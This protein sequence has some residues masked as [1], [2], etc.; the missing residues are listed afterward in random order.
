MKKLAKITAWA[1]LVL[2]LL[3]LGAGCSSDEGSKSEGGT[4]KSGGEGVNDIVLVTR[5]GRAIRFAENDVPSMGRVSQGVKGISSFIV[6]KETTDREAAERVG[7]GHGLGGGR[8]AGDGHTDSAATRERVSHSGC[9]GV[10]GEPG[11]GGRD[12]ARPATRR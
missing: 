10:G 11:A 5:Q 7:V 4:S 6:T 12:R 9:H 3:L 1:L 8:G 2:C